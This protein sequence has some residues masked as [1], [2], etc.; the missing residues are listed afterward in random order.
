MGGY[1]SFERLITERF[2]KALYFLGFLLLTSGG[3]GL[4]IWAGL[5]LHDASI[6]RQVGWRYVAMGIAAIILGNLLWRILCE[7]WIV[8]FN[9]HARLVA[10]DHGVDAARMNTVQNPVNT[11]DL[12]DG[13]DLQR[14]RAAAG[15]ESYES[16]RATSVLGLT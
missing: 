3:I 10:I 2:V 16:P 14:E 8:L 4:A 11:L 7:F 12:S 1:F 9:M 15:R 5:R 13:L 6:S